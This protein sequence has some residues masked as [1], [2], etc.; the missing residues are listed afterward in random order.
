MK[1]PERIEAP[2]DLITT[3]EVFEELGL[4]IDGTEG[5]V[6]THETSKIKRYIKTL[7][8]FMDGYNGYLGRC[9]MSQKW[10]SYGC[11]TVIQLPMPDASAVTVTDL[12]T[13][14]AITDFEL[15]NVPPLPTVT[16]K[17]AADVK[18]EATYG[19]GSA[20]DVPAPIIDEILRQILMRY[21]FPDTPIEKSMPM[22]SQYRIKRI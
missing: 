13:N 1:L 21:E 8:T 11:G 14:T 9:L 3:T 12:E 5:T 20:A 17:T 18:I 19:Y 15:K 10:R 2:A 7:V 4:V 6:D 16:L 22:V